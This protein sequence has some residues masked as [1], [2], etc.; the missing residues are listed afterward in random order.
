[1]GKNSAAATAIQKKA[2]IDALE[3]NFGN[4]TKAAVAAHI[5]PRTH[6]RWLKEDEDYANEAE[7][8]KDLCYRKVKDNLL[9]NALKKIDKGDSAVLNKMLGIFF[10]KMPEEMDRVRRFNDVPF[11]LKIKVAPHP[12]DIYA[13]DPMTQLAVKQYFAEKE[14]EGSLNE[15]REDLVEKYKNGTIGEGEPER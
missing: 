4:A 10:K 5:K 7:N 9:E 11:R 13:K 15:I 3:A 8:M 2:M 6:Y 12:Q 14:K 1:M